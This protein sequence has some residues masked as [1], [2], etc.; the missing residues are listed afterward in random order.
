MKEDK[1]SHDLYFLS[2]LKAI[3]WFPLQTIM[4][5]TISR[6]RL[7]MILRQNVVFSV[8]AHLFLENNISVFLKI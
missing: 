4:R 6:G 1:W 7:T 2:D 8:A 3:V 5:V